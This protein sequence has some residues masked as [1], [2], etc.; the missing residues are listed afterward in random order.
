M[1]GHELGAPL[2]ASLSRLVKFG[3]TWELGGDGP[4]SFRVD[5]SAGSFDGLDSFGAQFGEA[6]GRGG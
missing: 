4:G 2:V 1:L 3:A 6:G 5:L